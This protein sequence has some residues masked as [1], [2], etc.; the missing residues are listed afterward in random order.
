MVAGQGVGP[1]YQ[2]SKGRVLP[3]DDPAYVIYFGAVGETR[4]LM[5]LR[6]HAPEACL[7]TNFSTTAIYENFCGPGRARTYNTC[8]VNAVL[9]H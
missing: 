3:L 6:T 5:T 7:Y 9:C 4:T 2:P 1:R 8:D